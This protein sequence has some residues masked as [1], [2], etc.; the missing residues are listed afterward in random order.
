MN[1]RQEEK[2]KLKEA[3]KKHYSS[4]LEAQKKLRQSEPSRRIASALEEIKQSSLM[5]EMDEM[6][7]K[8]QEKAFLAEAK[9]EQALDLRF[10]EEVEKE[11]EEINKK[12]EAKKA[13][14]AIR[15]EMGDVYK[16]TEE[17]AKNMYQ[18]KTIGKQK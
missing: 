5:E 3:Y 7:K 16:D 12:F 14:D 17:K 2:D 8:V 15:A 18:K 4:L 11:K 1:K 13:V 6:V 10:E 9:L